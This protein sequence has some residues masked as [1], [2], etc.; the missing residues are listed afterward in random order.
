MIVSV[1]IPARN[2]EHFIGSCLASVKSAA[3]EIESDLEIVVVIN[4][5]TDSTEK[6]ARKEGAK[7]VYDDSKNL[8]K[9]RNT[10][11]RSSIGDIVFTIDAD[12]TMSIGFMEEALTLLATGKIIGGACRFMLDRKGVGIWLTQLV[13][14]MLTWM[15]NVAGGC[16]W[17]YR[18]DFER[19]G[20]F[21]ENLLIFEDVDFAKRLKMLGKSEKKKFKILQKN[22]IVTSARKIGQFGGW[23]FILRPWL[24]RE[25]FK[26]TNREIADK[27]W[28][29]VK[30]D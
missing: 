2:E 25:G 21:N 16:F 1:V 7:I 17:F 3:S 6:I 30:G 12:S 29:E 14:R 15:L 23:H 4:R 28:Y 9:I 11:V 24:I 27:Y 8:S 19:I 18:R 20:G 26:G 10:G 13:V 22:Y 5:C